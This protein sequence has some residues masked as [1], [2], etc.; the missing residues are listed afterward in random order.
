MTDTEPRPASSTRFNLIL[1]IATAVVGA[2]IVAGVAIATAHSSSSSRRD[3]L[4]PG[5][6]STVPLQL[7]S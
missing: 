1:V 5:V 7:P 6:S 4:P 3:R 2:L